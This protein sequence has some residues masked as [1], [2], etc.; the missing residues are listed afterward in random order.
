MVI[1]LVSYL[2]FENMYNYL[3]YLKNK[4][5]MVEKKFPKINIYDKNNLSINFEEEYKGKII[6]INLWNNS[7]GY[8]IKNFPKYEKLKN[9]YRNDTLVEVISINIQS[10]KKNIALS[11]KFLNKFTFSNFYTDNSIYEKLKINGVPYYVILDENFKIK[12]IGSLNT[13]KLET[14][15][16]IYDLIENEK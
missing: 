3:F 1:F 13:E 5:E 10:E 11:E 14:Y 15:N 9:H 7:C 2:N 4:S 12:Y 16:N 6:V 8:C